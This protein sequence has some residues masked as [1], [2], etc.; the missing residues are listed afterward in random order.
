VESGKNQYFHVSV[1]AIEL[2]YT[3]I[4]RKLKENVGKI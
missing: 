3:R 2:D 1:I 4:V